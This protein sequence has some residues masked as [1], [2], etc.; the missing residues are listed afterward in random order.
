M[1]KMVTTTGKTIDQDEI[2]DLAIKFDVTPFE[3]WEVYLYMESV[4][5]D[6]D[7]FEAEQL[8]QDA[9]RTLHEDGITPRDEFFTEMA[10][11]FIAV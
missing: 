5:E 1:S 9:S 2:T 4:M 11:L 10:K 3:A 7:Y 8:A 6:E